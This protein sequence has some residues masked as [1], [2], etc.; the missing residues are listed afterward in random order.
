MKGGV[1]VAALIAVGAVLV[2]LGIFGGGLLVISLGVV[3]LVA[4]GL[5]EA[6]GRRR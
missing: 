4:A 5:F 1:S 3:C 6:V 2:F